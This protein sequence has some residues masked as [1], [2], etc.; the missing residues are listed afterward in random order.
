[1]IGCQKPKV[2]QNF[3]VINSFPCGKCQDFLLLF[4]ENALNN[5]KSNLEIANTLTIVCYLDD[6]DYYDF[7]KVM[8]FCMQLVFSYPSV[9]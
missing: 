9:Q 5:A 1:M 7:N 4:T 3:P 6:D 2:G 8:T